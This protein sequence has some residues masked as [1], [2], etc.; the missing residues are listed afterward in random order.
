M[1]KAGLLTSIE[2]VRGIKLGMTIDEVFAVFPGGAND[3]GIKLDIA[4]ADGYPRFGMADMVFNPQNYST[5]D[6]F[7]GIDSLSFIFFDG[8]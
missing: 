8:R 2:V 6:R 1:G 4:R 7:T 3:D 5:R